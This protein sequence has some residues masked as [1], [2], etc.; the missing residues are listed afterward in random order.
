VIELWY[1]GKTLPGTLWGRSR[2]WMY[3][4][5]RGEKE[6]VDVYVSTKLSGGV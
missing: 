4:V 1:A 6:A 5:G 3:P 2:I